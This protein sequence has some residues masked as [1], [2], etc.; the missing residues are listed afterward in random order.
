MHTKIKARDKS[1]A[2]DN[3]IFLNQP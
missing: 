1:S 2:P 3:F